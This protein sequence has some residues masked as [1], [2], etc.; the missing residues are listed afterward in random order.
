MSVALD[1]LFAAIVKAKE[2]D[3]SSSRT[4]K[5]LREGPSKMA[6]KVVE[7]AIEVALDAVQGQRQRVVE[8]S[9][10]L[11]YNLA[12]LW[13]AIGISPQD[14]WSEIE[15]REQTYGIAEKLPKDGARR[16]G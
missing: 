13:S 8:E 2:L 1:R 11:L 3:P 9:A 4:A 6:K 14:V 15:W 12:V 5:L 10:D 7:E 16:E